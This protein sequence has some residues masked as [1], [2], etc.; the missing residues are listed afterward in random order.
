[1]PTAHHSVVALRFECVATAFQDGVAN[2]SVVP[3]PHVVARGNGEQENVMEIVAL[4]LKKRET[5]GRK[6]YKEFITKDNVN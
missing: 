3:D 6:A 2:G 5:D 1:M 4:F